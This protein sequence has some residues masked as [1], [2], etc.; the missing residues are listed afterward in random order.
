M[1]NVNLNK[2]TTSIRQRHALG[3]I[4]AAL[5]AREECTIVYGKPN[6]I[7][8]VRTI[9]P[10]TIRQCDNGNTVVMASCVHQDGA[11]R[12]FS[13]SG[14]FGAALGRVNPIVTL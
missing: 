13:V 14:I 10:H 8:N 9:L 2:P 6:G 3:V 4:G 5:T 1:P 12:Q 7:V 11:P